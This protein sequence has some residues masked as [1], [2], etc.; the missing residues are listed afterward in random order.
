MAST[1]N[2]KLNRMWWLETFPFYLTV[3]LWQMFNG[4]GHKLQE[5]TFSLVSCWCGLAEA[6]SVKLFV[7]F[8]SCCTFI[9]DYLIVLFFTAIDLFL[10]PLYVPHIP[11]KW[12]VAMGTVWRNC[13]LNRKYWTSWS[14][15]LYVPW[16]GFPCWNNAT[17]SLYAVW[18]L[19]DWGNP[20]FISHEVQLLID[21]L[22]KTKQTWELSYINTYC[23]QRGNAF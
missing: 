16:F 5:E 12:P 1:W 20:L 7:D 19:G 18:V 10:T 8:I 4:I 11:W 6:S 23:K 17:K 15:Q 9:N 2:V 3:C 21:Q 22:W 14:C 13:I